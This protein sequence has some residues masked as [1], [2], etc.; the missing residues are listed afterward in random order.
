MAGSNVAYIFTPIEF[1]GAERVTLAF[2][3]N[4]ERAT[5]RITPIVL[6]RPWERD[7]IVLRELE[8]EGYAA[9][10]VP[11]ACRPRSA[12]RD[13]FR[14]VRCYR[15]IHRILS[16]GSFDLVHTHGYFADILGVPAA[17]VLGIPHIATCHGFIDNDRALRLYNRLDRTALRFSKRIIAVS[18]DIRADLLSRGID[19]ERVCTL[20][21]A[22]PVH[23]LNGTFPSR[24]KK[25]RAALGLGDREF[26]IGFA[27]RLSEEKGL[28][29]LIAASALLKGEGLRSRT[30]L[31][32]DGP[33]QQE[34][35][36][37]ADT[38]G[39]RQDV[40]FAGFRSDVENLL[41]AF[42]VFVLPSVTEGTPMALLEAMST[43]IPVV[44][45]AVGGVPDVID[46]D[47]NGILIPAGDPRAI[48][49]A[50]F[51]L[52]RNSALRA[53]LAVQALKTIREKYNVK[54]WTDRVQQ[55]YQAAIN[56]P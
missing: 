29:Y 37:L 21:N 9:L 32:G 44:A 33:Q 20:R 49:D 36:S 41:P 19:P 11:V 17:R 13:W 40:L 43:G 38:E 55:E 54:D 30:V 24:R 10:P 16:N 26:V 22:V 31:L 34:L 46:H 48:S 50:L 5:F 25:A 51:K 7:N 12:G 52:N 47:Q 35:K 42:D 28:R 15:M 23:D 8:K 6:I 18:D 45:S 2:L 1:G 27:G 3:K 39:L 14:L 56:E 4:V 53:M